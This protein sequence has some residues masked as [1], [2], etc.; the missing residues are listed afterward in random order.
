[1]RQK[2]LTLLAV[3]AVAVSINTPAE[4]Q[5]C[6][7]VSPPVCNPVRENVETVATVVDSVDDAGAKAALEAIVDKESEAYYAICGDTCPTHGAMPS[8]S[9][10]S[11]VIREAESRGA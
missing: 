10:D 7:V 11:A 5:V 4:A 1:M 9:T 8:S 3:V 2:V 6:N